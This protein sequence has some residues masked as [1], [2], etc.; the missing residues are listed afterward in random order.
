[1]KK[2]KYI[3]L[4]LAAVMSLS[5]CADFLDKESDTEMTIDEI[6][7]QRILQERWLGR[8]YSAIDDPYWGY[9]RYSGFS[10]L[11]DDLMP[12]QRWEPYWNGANGPMAMLSGNWNTQTGWEGNYWAL[13]PQRIRE[14]L[15][16]QQR[17]TP[18]PDEG[19]PASE[20]E[21]MKIECRFLI[22]YYC[23]RMLMAYGPFPFNPDKIWPTESSVGDLMYG[24]TPW[25]D[26][27]DWIDKELLEVS[28]LLPARYTQSNKFGR[29]DK[30]MCL[31]VRARLLLFNASPLVN[32]NPDYANHVDNEG[33]HLFPTSYDASQ[34]KR[35]ADACKLLIDEAHAAGG[36][37]YKEYKKDG[38]IDPF[39]SYQN[40][41]L[42][43]DA[44]A[45]PEILF[46][47]QSSDY[48]SLEH[49][50]TTIN[51]G[52]NGGLGVVQEYVD[53][54]FMKNGRKIDDPRSGYKEEGFSDEDDVRETAWTG[55]KATG[56]NN[57]K[58]ITLAGTYNMYCNREPR[59]YTGI[60]FNGA[61]YSQENRV[62][63]MMAGQIDNN[64]SH[65]APQNGYLNR[66]FLHYD[67]RPNKNT[68]KWRPGILYRL[69]EAYLN[70]AE[71]LNE[72]GGQSADEILRYVN[73][74]RERAGIP[75]YTTA[76]V[77]VTDNSVIH[78]DNTQEALRK[79]IH[80]ERR[81]E[82]GCEG[83]R[84]NDLRRW[85]ECEARLN[86][87]Q[88]GMNFRGTTPEEFYK[89]TEA[90][91]KRVY[92]KAF[93]FWPVHQSEMDKNPNL[94]QGPYWTSNAED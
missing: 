71:A 81:I 46:A 84:Y 85:K 23:E 68:G 31:A 92:K 32:G 1:M 90:Q 41:F 12:S 4:A 59:F 69:G 3:L 79:V 17:A 7:S 28:K 5:S 11:G 19:L 27:V 42:S 38:S 47:R 70:Y 76:A 91:N 9:T 26:I 78:V 16:F 2:F 21:L 80:D 15:I 93:Y 89:R 22:A 29:A 13:M 14:C 33:V 37:L 58:I 82:L 40:L 88:H 62:Y 66:K 75:G 55:G 44:L 86:G 67:F 48:N 45:N 18:V 30:L 52:G 20:V 77:A 49:H 57:K 43:Q 51:T 36:E 94:I 8:C 39:L 65:D 74:I 6:F 50:S 24:P 35:A 34:W 53:D 61:W 63:Q 54:F 73:L 64:T 83:I 25:S 72:M 60:V 87:Y 10:I 56:D